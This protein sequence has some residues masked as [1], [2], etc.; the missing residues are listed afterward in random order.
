MVTLVLWVS[1]PIQTFPKRVA[2]KYF[3][4]CIYEKDNSLYTSDLVSL[5]FTEIMHFFWIDIESNSGVFGFN[6]L[7][8]KQMPSSIWN[9]V[10][11]HMI[12][13]AIIRHVTWYNNSPKP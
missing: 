11:F 10:E 5:H 8:I 2:G 3:S 7:M 1:E 12:Y 13:M 6:F 9:F 4:S